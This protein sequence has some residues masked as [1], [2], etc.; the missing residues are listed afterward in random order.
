MLE[1]FISLFGG[2]HYGTKIASEKAESKEHDKKVAAWRSALELWQEKVTDYCL[3]TE[4]EEFVKNEQNQD[5]LRRRIEELCPVLPDDQ[6]SHNNYIRILLASKGKIR[7]NDAIGGIT[8]PV[9]G[10]SAYAEIVQNRMRFNDYMRWLD[11]KLRNNGVDGRLVFEPWRTPGKDN[12]EKRYYELDEV[13]ELKARHGEFLWTTQAIH[14]FF[15]S[16]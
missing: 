5:E 12:D 2:I 10:E 13:D 1:F 3:E 8:P 16:N 9:Y 15:Q 7:V 11:E 14:L 6:K 4:I